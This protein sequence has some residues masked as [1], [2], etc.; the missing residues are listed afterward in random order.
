MLKLG[1]LQKNHRADNLIAVESFDVAKK[2]WVKLG[3]V[4]FD[5]QEK[6]FGEG[7]FRKAFRASSKNAL[8]QNNTWVLKKYHD[9]AQQ[10]V[11][12][13]GTDFESQARKSVQMHCL[14]RHLA[15]AFEQL[16]NETIESFGP[17]FRY[18]KVYYGLHGTQHVTIEEY[19]D[20]EFEKY[21][22]NT[23]VV[24]CIGEMREKAE[25]FVHFTWERSGG[26]FMILDIQGA[27]YV[28][29]DLEI[30]TIGLRDKEGDAS[31]EFYFCMGNLSGH[32]I[33]AFQ[34]HHKCNK[35]CKT[36]GFKKF[37]VVKSGSE[38]EA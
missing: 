12:D 5:V 8:F 23:G 2:E 31:S 30:A 3:E 21:V 15:Q 18:N 34:A 35:I 10:L 17:A 28:L 26:N 32:A 19:I 27:G 11:N 4:K 9:S 16:C 7:G 36:L 37:E 14:S 29:S 22:N 33:R 1:E 24:Y 13:L 38:D 25:A 6:H 20:G